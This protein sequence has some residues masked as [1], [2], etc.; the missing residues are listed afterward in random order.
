M[1]G[2][3]LFAT[4]QSQPR[5]DRVDRSA[6]ETVLLHSSFHF[7]LFFIKYDKEIQAIANGNVACKQRRASLSHCDL[8]LQSNGADACLPQQDRS[9][10]IAH[11]GMEVVNVE[12]KRATGKVARHHAVA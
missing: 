2:P 3:R 10:I 12:L 11:P 5:N 9:G 1:A 7:P 6:V 8:S 4:S